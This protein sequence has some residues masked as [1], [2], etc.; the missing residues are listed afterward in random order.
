M[1]PDFF[2]V[3]ITLLIAARLCWKDWLSARQA[4]KERDTRIALSKQETR[5]LE[6][7]ASVVTQPSFR[8]NEQV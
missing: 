7:M 6:V 5:R 1:S 8:A 3:A 4:E 2:I